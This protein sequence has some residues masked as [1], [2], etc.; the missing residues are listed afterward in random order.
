MPNGKTKVLIGLV[1]LF[2]IFVVIGFSLSKRQ[3]PTPSPLAQPKGG[4]ADVKGI[5]QAFGGSDIKSEEK[6][7]EQITK[8]P[9]S[10]EDIVNKMKEVADF[11]GFEKIVYED[12]KTGYKATFTSKMNPSG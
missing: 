12:G 4:Y 5:Q 6:T 1:V 8:L 7:K 11:S 2:I 3:K 9:S 10:L